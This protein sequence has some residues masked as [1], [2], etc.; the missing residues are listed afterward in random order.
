[1]DYHYKA[2]GEQRMHVRGSV[3]VQ[4]KRGT[5]CVHGAPGDGLKIAAVNV[6]GRLQPL[7]GDRSSHPNHARFLF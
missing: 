6:F 4:V 2:Q 7:I 5:R 3:G 1:M